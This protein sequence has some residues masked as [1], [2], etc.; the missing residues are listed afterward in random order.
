[1]ELILIR[2]ST[3]QG[4]KEKRFIG[5]LDIPISED[6]EELARRV[7]PGLPE[8]EHLYRSPLQRCRQTADLLWPGVEQTV[9][10]QLRETDFGPFEGKC[11]EELKDDPLYQQWIS[12]SPNFAKMP[13]G[14]SAEAC[15]ARVEEGI[16]AVIRQAREAGYTRVAVVTHGGT[17]MGLLSRFGQPERS[18]Y[19]WMCA[20]CGGYQVQIKE[21][22]LTLE[23][24]AP[25]G[26][27]AMNMDH[28]FKRQTDES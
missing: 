18:Y 4:N 24:V 9:I 19:D 3:T 5:T 21:D 20:N 11:H 25:V 26:Q 22:P 7:S 2:H 8:V 10:A 27:G 15:A 6:G 13:V 23:V 14:E 16:R 17:L 28:M 1:M 12:D